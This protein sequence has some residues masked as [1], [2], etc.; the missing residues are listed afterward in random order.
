MP[1]LWIKH[2]EDVSFGASRFE[3]VLPPSELKDATGREASPLASALLR[4][5][6]DGRFV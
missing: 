6:G 3:Q 4:G 2:P 1:P 5:T